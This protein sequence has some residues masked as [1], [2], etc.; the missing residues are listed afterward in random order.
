MS[1]K[2]LITGGAG[3]IGSNLA[4]KLQKDYPENQYF[5]I[6]NFSSGSYENLVDFR[7]DVITGSLAKINLE[8]YF[9]KG[10]DVIFHQ[11]SITD[12]TCFDQEKM[13]FENVE[14]FRNVLE[15]AKKFNAQIIYASSAAVYGLSNPPMKEG[16]NE[17]P[18]NIYGFSKLAMDN[19][20]KQ[21]FENLKITGLRYFNVYGPKEAHKGKM[22]SMVWQMY[23]DIKAGKAPKLFEFGDQS[24]DQVYVKDIVNANILAWQKGKSGIFNVGSGKET[25]FNDILENINKIL[26]TNIK[27]QYI[28]NPYSHY[29]NNTLADLSKTKEQLGY[30]AQY[31][32]EKGTEDYLNFLE[33]KI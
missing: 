10:Y 3:F 25:T 18:A 20:A 9:P 8:K 16:F 6:D 29:Q 17:N 12:T 22:A 2:I 24:R 30:E 4:L 11:A 23:V 19:I 1:K 13:M 5:I 32:I 7:G 26:K 28:K 21:N 27:A 14:G 31:S 15:L 33:Q